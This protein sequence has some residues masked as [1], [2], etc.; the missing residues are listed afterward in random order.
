[1]VAQTGNARAIWEGGDLN[2]EFQDVISVA[3][4]RKRIF[5]LIFIMAVVVVIS[6]TVALII[7]YE[8]AF[9]QKRASLA[10]IAQSQARLIE[11]VARFDQSFSQLDHPDGA[12]AATISQIVDAHSKFRHVARTEEIMLSRLNS[13]QI[14]FLLRQRN[15]DFEI[16]QSLPLESLIAEPTRLALSGKTGTI[17]G[18]DYRGEKVLAAYEPVE[19][20]NL[21]IVAKINLADIRGPFIKAGIALLAITLLVIVTG[22]YTFVRISNPLIRKIIY[23]KERA[24]S[25]NRIKTEF[26]A[27]MSHEFRTPLNAILGYSEMIRA[28]YFGPLG[29]EKYLDYA[30]DIH[31][32]G[33]H[34]LSLTNDLL[35]LAAIEAGKSAITKE[36]IEVG[37]ALKECIS[38]FEHVAKEA[39]IILSASIPNDLPSLHAD[40]RS[41]VQIFLNLLSNAV[42]FTERGGV[43]DL[44]VRMSDQ[45]MII[46]VSDTG[47]GI[48]HDKLPSITEPFSQALDDPYLAKKGTGLGLSIVKS[49]VEA[50]DG[51]LTIDSEYGKRTTATIVFPPHLIVNG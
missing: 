38:G 34:M 9:E 42:K 12:A 49:L 32:S 48:Q 21:G 15:S 13:N 44:S 37:G 20:L 4:A 31:Q 46:A 40:K 6:S 39:G 25:A 24:E 47:I 14:E 27:T 33:Q 23:E 19:I 50:H 16:P 35:D 7:L 45:K 8:T 51:E 43:V 28:Q 2:D 1:M 3:D 41:F 17:V 36:L 18:L 29:A 10:Q 5:F 11:A 30:N 22:T 26:L